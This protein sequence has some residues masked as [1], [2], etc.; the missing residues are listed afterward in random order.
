MFDTPVA[1]TAKFIKEDT[2]AHGTQLVFPGVSTCV[3][4]V[5]QLDAELVGW[6]VTMDTL[7]HLTERVFATGEAKFLEYLGANP[8][9]VYIVGHTAGHDPS[10]I[11]DH[12]NG[13][14]VGNVPT[15]MFDITQHSKGAVGGEYHLFFAHVANGHPNVF[16]K[17]SKKVT[18]SNISGGDANAP[19]G[20]DK[21]YLPIYNRDADFST[22]N[23][24]PVLRKHFVDVV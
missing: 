11:R 6:H 14:V 7:D 1:L 10:A 12:I 19:H 16:F 23:T 4:V 9:R 17:T 2:A 21:G 3:A 20:L 8:R 18:E 15:E 5:A 13:A 22:Q 24:H